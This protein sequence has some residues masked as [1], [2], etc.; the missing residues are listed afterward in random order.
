MNLIT[1]KV[2]DVKNLVLKVFGNEYI[3]AMQM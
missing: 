3:F 2:L 1:T